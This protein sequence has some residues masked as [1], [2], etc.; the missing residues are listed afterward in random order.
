MS[1]TP[2][3]ARA[4]ARHGLAHKF[5]VAH[6]RRTD[7]GPRT[8]IASTCRRRLVTYAAAELHLRARLAYHLAS[9]RR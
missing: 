1:I 4:K 5:R 2:R 3:H 9:W 8:P 7:H 6:R